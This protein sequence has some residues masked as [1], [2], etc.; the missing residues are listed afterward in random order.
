MVTELVLY[1]FNVFM[2]LEIPEIRV[3]LFIVGK[4]RSQNP[5]ILGKS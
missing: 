3:N 5:F 1:H 2:L 4:T